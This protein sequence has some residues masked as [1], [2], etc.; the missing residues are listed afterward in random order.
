MAM[1]RGEIIHAAAAGLAW[2]VLAVS[3]SWWFD[4]WLMGQVSWG[5]WRKA[6]P[7]GV[8]LGVS[9]LA[10]KLYGRVA[11]RARERTPKAGETPPVTGSQA[12]KSVR[13]GR[14]PRRPKPVAAG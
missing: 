1:K 4:S 2:A 9:V 3:L 8:W 6:I 7:Y 11:D 10:S 13:K 12:V 5:L 14:S